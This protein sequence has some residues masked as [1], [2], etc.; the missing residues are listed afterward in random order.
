MHKETGRKNLNNKQNGKQKTFYQCM[1]H[2]LCIIHHRS[3]GSLLLL[4]NKGPKG[5][6]F[7]QY[8]VY[9]MP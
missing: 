1:Y 8:G 9:I 6:L 2:S 7:I 4:R 5:I 3:I